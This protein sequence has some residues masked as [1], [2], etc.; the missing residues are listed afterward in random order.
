VV[1]LA[2]SDNDSITQIVLEKKFDNRLIDTTACMSAIFSDVYFSNLCDAI[3]P[4]TNHW[5]VLILCILC[6]KAIPKMVICSKI[7]KTL[8]ARIEV[9]CFY[10]HRIA[11][12]THTGWMKLKGMQKA[13]YSKNTSSFIPHMTMSYTFLE[14]RPF[15]TSSVT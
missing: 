10:L 11:Y 2:V 13:N 7:N 3:V 4:L 12:F 15:S 8:Y 14:I 5:A 9:V 6:Y 1:P